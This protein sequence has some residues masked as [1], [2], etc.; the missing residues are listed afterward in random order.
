[1]RKGER[2][3]GIVKRVTISKK[4]SSAIRSTLNRKVNLR[5]SNWYEKAAIS[6]SAA[7]N[8]D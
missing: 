5:S 7:P 4:A 8:R 2:I 1:M 6:I 3:N